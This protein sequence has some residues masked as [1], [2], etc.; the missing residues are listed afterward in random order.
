[1]NA[2][3]A[4]PRSSRELKRRPG[5]GSDI[6]RWSARS[7]RRAVPWPGANVKP[8][9]TPPKHRRAASDVRSHRSRL[10]VAVAFAVLAAA[11]VSVAVLLPERIAQRAQVPFARM[12]LPRPPE[13]M[14]EA[15]EA[16]RATSSAPTPAEPAVA[17]TPSVR[18]GHGGPAVDS[19]RQAVETARIPTDPTSRATQQ[20]PARDT[21][22]PVK[23]PPQPAVPPATSSAPERAAPASRLEE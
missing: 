23:D 4:C 1:M 18:F 3:S 2:R 21:A 8:N 7:N 20:P 5:S 14:A 13:K 19:K 16:S 6:W 15:P 12:E 17:P 10:L 22:S 9:L 11:A